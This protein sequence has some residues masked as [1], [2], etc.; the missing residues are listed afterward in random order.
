MPTIEEASDA[1]DG[2]IDTLGD[3]QNALENEASQTARVVES[4]KVNLQA[5]IARAWPELDSERLDERAAWLDQ[6]AGAPGAVFGELLQRLQDQNPEFETEAEELREQLKAIDASGDLASQEKTLQSL[7]TEYQEAKGSLNE[8]AKPFAQILTHNKE[9]DNKITPETFDGIKSARGLMHSVKMLGSAYRSA[10]EAAQGYQSKTGSF[11]LDWRGLAVLQNDADKKKSALTAQQKKMR[12][13]NS[14]EEKISDAESKIKSPEDL[15]AALNKT[16]CDLALGDYA[17]AANLVKNAGD[18]LDGPIAVTLIAAQSL[19]K[20]AEGLTMQGEFIEEIIGRLDAQK[21][22]LDDAVNDDY[23]NKDV[24]TDIR[25]PRLERSLQEQI[26]VADQ[27]VKN[28]IGFRSAIS[29]YVPVPLGDDDHD[30]NPDSLLLYKNQLLKGLLDRG[31]YDPDY[32][33]YVMDVDPYNSLVMGR[34][35]LSLLLQGSVYDWNDS[36][37]QNASE[38]IGGSLNQAG[39]AIINTLNDIYDD[40]DNWDADGLV[41]DTVIIAGSVVA[42]ELVVDAAFDA[43]EAIGDLFGL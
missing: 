19:Q 21:D 14:V 28:S 20:S 31:N 38:R 39:N 41:K 27:R 12:E 36:C 13:R 25:L 43:A 42:A 7:E 35:G 30:R 29:M 22:K 5:L 16:A 8:A 2:F 23:D 9:Y 10:F 6:L 34:H 37:S 1:Y 32:T 3:R 11:D 18:E 40:E 33:Y 15:F 17:F 24:G 26:D 4:A